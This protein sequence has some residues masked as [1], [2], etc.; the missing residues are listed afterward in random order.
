MA[1]KVFIS[2]L[3]TNNYT[4]CNYY[5][6]NGSFVNNIKYV[7]EATMNEFCNDYDA[8]VFFLTNEAK[9]KN[10]IGES[11]LNNRLKNYGDKIIVKDIPSGFNLT[12]IWEIFDIVYKEINEND[13]L[14]FDITHAFRSL[15]MLGMVLINYLKAVKNVEINGVYYGAFEA[16]GPQYLVK[17]MPVEERNVEILDLIG[18]SLLQEWTIAANN[19]YEFGNVE[20]LSDLVNKQIKPI[21]AESKGKDADANLLRSFI[22]PLPDIFSD[23]AT[24]R[25]FELYKS[26]RYNTIKKALKEIDSTNM[27]QLKPLLKKIEEKIVPFKQ[28][29]RILNGFYVVK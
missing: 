12:E 23:I 8:F 7:Q 18:F 17:E 27:P 20:K 21:L 22:K 29:E 14:V 1:R 16:L 13:V 3:G 9:E 28:E 4:P 6:A 25:A 19:F 2:F 10:W 24:V 15:P 11:G 26:D 5:T